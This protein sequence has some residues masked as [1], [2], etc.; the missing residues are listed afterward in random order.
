MTASLYLNEKIVLSKNFLYSSSYKKILSSIASSNLAVKPVNLKYFYPQQISLSKRSLIFDPSNNPKNI[1]DSDLVSFEIE[2]KAFLINLKDKCGDRA[3]AILS[4]YQRLGLFRKFARQL[5]NPVLN[6]TINQL[7]SIPKMPFFEKDSPLF[8]K[9]E[10]SAL[11]HDISFL[12]K[13]I[14]HSNF[15]SSFPQQETEKLTNSF[16]DL[17]IACK[18]LKDMEALLSYANALLLRYGNSPQEEK[19]INRVKDKSFFYILKPGDGPSALS[20]E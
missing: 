1:A 11:Y 16:A 12:V 13:N 10:R 2:P 18:R 3:R 15:F 6:K 8:L 7:Y 5:N 14:F 17:D 9:G 4:F 19:T 20:L